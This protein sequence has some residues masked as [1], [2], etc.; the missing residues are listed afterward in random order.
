MEQ[1][2]KTAHMS[3]FTFM[4]KIDI[5]INSGDG[6]LFLFGRTLALG[7]QE[8]EKITVLSVAQVLAESISSIHEGESMGAVFDKM[9]D[10]MEQG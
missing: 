2:N 6:F 8:H 1:F 5:H 3:A 7:A 10:D 9:R 4:W